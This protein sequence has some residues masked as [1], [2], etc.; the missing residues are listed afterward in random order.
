ME[1]V[2]FIEGASNG[3]RFEEVEVCKEHIAP[4]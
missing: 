1:K 2:N 3:V 4:S